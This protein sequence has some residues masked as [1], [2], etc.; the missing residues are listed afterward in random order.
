MPT[1]TP[2]EVRSCIEKV[3]EESI[4]L[5]LKSLYLLGA[6]RAY[7]M[8]GKIY[9]GDSTHRKFIHG[10]R[11]SDASLTE[12]QPQELS[13]TQATLILSGKASFEEAF[14]P[15]PVA[16]F[17]IK[18]AKSH[19]SEEPKSRLIGLPYEEKYEPWTKEIYNYFKKAGDNYVFPFTRQKAWH[20]ITYEEP[21]FKGLTYP[22]EA[23]R[24]LE[25]GK[26]EKEPVPSHDK[27]FKLHGLRH[28]RVKEL[29]ESYGFDGLDFAAYIGWSLRTAKS[30][31]D[32][33]TPVSPMLK[34]YATITRNWKRYFP[35][36]LKITDIKHL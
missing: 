12:Y 35:K 1:P 31:Q 22:V 25:T 13:P 8:V 19:I 11:G 23:Y 16:L 32:V 4:R 27:V 10:P 18:T 17:D 30:S 36:L 14:R 3:Q 29:Y 28:V 26:M 7:E 21:V 5:Y 34:V 33:A 15:I 6:A 2:E 20:W 9:E 24:V